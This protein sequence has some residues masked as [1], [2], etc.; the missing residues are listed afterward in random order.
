MELNL[1]NLE[2]Q[3]LKALARSLELVS[4]RVF[5]SVVRTNQL[6]SSTTP[7]MQNLFE[8]WLTIIARELL[9]IVG[10]EGKIDPEAV[11]EQIGITPE[12]VLGLAL[13]LQRQ[14]QIKIKSV[15]VES[16]DGRNTDICGCMGN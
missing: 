13:T 9:R 5:E 3:D 7:E 10:E 2:E 12:S 15:E 14:G 8:Q 6:A 1:N 16:G 4:A 11:A